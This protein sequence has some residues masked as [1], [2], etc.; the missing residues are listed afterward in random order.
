MKNEKIKH[1]VYVDESGKVI[2]DRNG[3][4]MKVMVKVKLDEKG[5]AV[6]DEAGDIIH[7]QVDSEGNVILNEKGEEI[8]IRGNQ[9]DD[10]DDEAN[11]ASSKASYYIEDGLTGKI[12]KLLIDKNSTTYIELQKA[13]R[14]SKVQ[15]RDE[16]ERQAT[17][18]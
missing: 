18:R 17:E 12:R 2:V 4:P 15:F 9:I 14:L 6:R 16:Y 3:F 1:V 11:S 8:G 13:I 10:S 7:V 5:I